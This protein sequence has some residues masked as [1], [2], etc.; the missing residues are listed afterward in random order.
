MKRQEGDLDE[1]DVANHISRFKKSSDRSHAHIPFGED[2]AGL[3]DGKLVP[4]RSERS[5]L[6]L[7]LLV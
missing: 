4:Y 7:R 3:L 6:H 2:A 1:L 5:V